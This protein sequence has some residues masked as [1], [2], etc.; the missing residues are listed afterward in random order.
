MQYCCKSLFVIDFYCYF[1]SSN[2]AFFLNNYTTILPLRLSSHQSR[3]NFRQTFA[4]LCFF[5]EIFTALIYLLNRCDFVFIF[6]IRIHCRGKMFEEEVCD[7]LYRSSDP[8]VQPA[9][10]ESSRIS[11][12]ISSMFCCGRNKDLNA[13]GAVPGR[14]SDLLGKA[15]TTVKAA[16]HRSRFHRLLS[17]LCPCGK[18]D[19]AVDPE[20]PPV[21]PVKPPAKDRTPVEEEDEPEGQSDQLRK[22]ATRHHWCRSVAGRFFELARLD[23]ESPNFPDLEEDLQV[24]TRG[25]FKTVQRKDPELREQLLRREWQTKLRA[26]FSEYTRLVPLAMRAELDCKSELARFK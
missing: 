7:L 9:S 25:M 8:T 17:C 23:K 6:P 26:R 21:D 15:P 11:K 12:M 2:N 5:G 3:V 19:A 4:S 16:R 1:L 14:S 10:K 24:V 13:D 22:L 20:E 18:V